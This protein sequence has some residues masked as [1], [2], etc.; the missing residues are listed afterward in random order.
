[1]FRRRGSYIYKKCKICAASRKKIYKS[2]QWDGVL[3]TVLDRSKGC[4][5]CGMTDKVCLGFFYADFTT[6]QYNF[7]KALWN[8]DL[9]IVLDEL[10]KCVILC[11]NCYC[12]RSQGTHSK[13]VGVMDAGILEAIECP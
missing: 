2:K 9:Q 11:Q 13:N 1:M 6:P 10:K 7:T 12:Q 3:N 4:M 5:V 8:N